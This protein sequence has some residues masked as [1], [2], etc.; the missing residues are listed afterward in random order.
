MNNAPTTSTPEQGAVQMAQRAQVFPVSKYYDTAKSRWVKIPAIP[1]GKNWR[2][3]KANPQTLKS[4]ANRGIVIPQGRVVIDLDVYKGVTREAVDEVLG[5]VLD[6]EGARVQ[7]TIGGGEHY[8]FSLPDGAHVLQGDSLLGLEGFNTRCAGEGWICTGDGYTDLTLIGMPTALAVEDFPALPQAALDALN[9]KPLHVEVVNKAESTISEYKTLMPSGLN[10]QQG[11]LLL[12]NFNCCFIRDGEKRPIGDSWQNNP[13]SAGEWNG[14]GI[15]VICG[16]RGDIAIHALDCDIRDEKLAKDMNEFLQDY[17]IQPD[18]AVLSRVGQ[19]P[20]FLIP[21]VMDEQIS[22]SEFTSAKYHP[23]GEKP[24]KYNTSQ[25]EVLGTG[26]QFVAYAIHPDTHN[27]YVWHRFLQGDHDS[28]YQVTPEQ[29]PK[30]TRD[31]LAE[32]KERFEQ[33]VVM[34]GL[35]TRGKPAAS[36]TPKPTPAPETTPATTPA[37]TY[38]TGGYELSEVLP[39]LINNDV[40]YD[41]W[42]KVGAAIKAEGGSYENW[43]SFSR[44]SDKHDETEMAKKW[45]SFTPRFDGAGMGTLAMYALQNGMPARDDE[46]NRRNYA[47]IL[48]DAAQLDEE[49]EPETIEALV[50]ETLHLTPAQRRKVHNSIK[51]KTKIPLSVLSEIL[52]EFRVSNNDDG[53]PDE[54]TLARKVIDNIGEENILSALEAVWAW[55][56]AGKWR[57]LDDRTVKK[58]SQVRLPGEVDAVSARLVAA[59]S[60]LMRTEV[61]RPFHEF[62]VGEPET[63]NCINGELV[64]VN[65]Q[66][67]LTPHCREHYRTAQIP[68]AYDPAASAPLFQRFLQ[69]IFN[70]DADAQDKIKALLEMTGYTLMA[71]CRH[72]KFV[73]L[74]GSGANGK[75]VY[76]AILEALCGSESVAGVQPSQFDNKFQRAHLHNKL[77]N[78]VTEVKQGEV[79]D[80][81]AL[82]GIVSGEPTTVEHKHKNPFVMRPFSTCWFGT[83]HMP[84]TRDFSDALFRRA[85]VMTFNQVFKPELGN[86]DPNLKDKLMPELSGILNLSLQAY[87]DALQHGFTMPAS[88]VDARNEWRLE[89]DQVAQFVGDECECVESRE[90]LVSVLYRSYEFWA[91]NNGIQK[92]VA[93]RSFRERLTRLGFGHKRD[94]RGNFIL[95]LKFKLVLDAG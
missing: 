74:V 60:D 53:E 65:G 87:A 23:E 21:F 50:A 55:D 34:H 5:V 10:S 67:V 31:E 91:I 22:K 48:S 59:V 7:R 17:L 54:L 38:K 46:E 58:L 11:E 69:Q 83:N 72:E 27:P 63:V 37:T 64:L 13:R 24:T 90:L 18:K 16:Q 86:C 77:A 20:K 75:S 88:S 41:E 44:Q 73:I 45:E 85:L 33:L 12:T 9:A 43:L 95:G 84:H 15:G 79:I 29:L 4:S 78:I 57:Q 93:L 40:D 62:N 8:A 28:L 56:N 1:K 6:W 71:H 14:Q 32:I 49:S 81:A 26:N 30:L 39:Y 94:S 68:V 66:W 2:T 92:K 19:A 52:D 61:H 47:D 35:V 89:A 82:K 42:I 36:P 70:G 25:L 3:Y 80:D 51:K 76:L